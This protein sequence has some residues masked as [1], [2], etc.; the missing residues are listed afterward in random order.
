MARYFV[1]TSGW[2]YDDW[3][4]KFYPENLPQEKWLEFYSSRFNTLELNN[5]F[6]H[7]PSEN[8]FANWYASSPP[9]F[10]FAVKASRFIT[11]TKRLKD[12]D[13][14]IANIMSRARLLQDKLGPLLY[15][16]PPGLRRDD[17]LL[18]TFMKK[19]PPDLKHAIE[20]R[21]ESW[22]TEEVYAILRKY[23]VG[24]CVFDMP[25]LASPIVATGDFAYIRFH[26]RDSLYSSCY[27][28]EEMAA[29]ARKIRIISKNLES[30]YIYFNNDVA[31]YALENA[32]TIHSY[33]V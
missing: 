20:F 32:R 21:H 30:V 22:H 15:Q 12:C 16:L 1:G 2:H 28:D 19:I 33:L 29:W 27:A 9:G 11:H 18:E 6:Y 4:G 7:L 26:G 17:A 5:S 23:R 13:D 10:V 25:K 8:A 31:G 3:R 24:F 14:A